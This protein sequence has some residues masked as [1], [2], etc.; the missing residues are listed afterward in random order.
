MRPVSFIPQLPCGCA[1]RASQL[2]AEFPAKNLPLKRLG[3]GASKIAYEICPKHVLKVTCNWFEG[4]HQGNLEIEFWLNSS[5]E[6]RQL[7]AP[8]V[9]YKRCTE[10]MPKRDQ[11]CKQ[12]GWH[13]QVKA[14]CKW[15]NLYDSNRMLYDHYATI[16]EEIYRQ[17]T[18]NDLYGSNL[19]IIDGKLVAVDYGFGVRG[20]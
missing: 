16:A 2:L 3:E 6:I 17:T 12:I 19:G 11:V 20:W 4:K 5:E 1:E 13:I 7:L 9:A 15:T 8:I 10:R 14:D 18:L